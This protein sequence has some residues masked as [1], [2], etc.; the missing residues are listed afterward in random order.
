VLLV[1]ESPPYLLDRRSMACLCGDLG[2]LTIRR[3]DRYGIQFCYKLCIRC[4][5][6]RTSNP[7]TNESERRFY[8]SSDYRTLYFPGEEP[9]QVLKRKT[10]LRN[11][12]SAL[13]RYVESLQTQPGTI[14][15]WGCGGGWNLIPF[16]DA[17]WKTTGYDYDATYLALGREYLG[18]DL[19]E[20]D[21]LGGNVIVDF[22]PNVILLNHVLEHAS[23]PISQL[24]QLGRLAGPST[25]IVVGVPLLET[26]KHWHWRDFFHV[27]HVHYFSARSLR[28]AA[29]SA[30]LRVVDERIPD[31]LFAL[32]VGDSARKTSSRNF[33]GVVTSGLFLLSGWIDPKFRLRSLVRITLKAIG[34]LRVARRVRDRLKQ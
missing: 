17:G 28:A 9:L 26:L 30:G 14:L 5:H 4:G 7:L 20:L 8:S 31:G 11:E 29:E 12:K 25:L 16:R 24:V 21:A 2:G 18:L 23:D 1:I 32:Q 33:Q 22:C 15:E 34:V 6:V 3:K 10:P 13:L 27:A 19:N